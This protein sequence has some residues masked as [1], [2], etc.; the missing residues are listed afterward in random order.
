MTSYTHPGRFSVL[1]LAIL[2]ILTV[3]PAFAETPP[4]TLD[5]IRAALPDSSITDGKVVYVDFWASWCGPCRQSFPWMQTLY[6]KY[7]KGGLEIIAVNVDKNHKDARQFLSQTDVTFSVIYDSTGKIA[8][9]YGL[10]A[11]PSSFIY[12]RSGKLVMQNC[13]FQKSEADSLDYSIL[14]LLNEGRSK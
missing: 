9:Q 7:H 13:G 5:I 8:K 11:M 14:E 12:D 1:T 3:G 10:E 4:A 2:T 6:D